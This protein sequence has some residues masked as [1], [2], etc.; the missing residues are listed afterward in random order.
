LRRKNACETLEPA[1]IKE[2][3][4]DSGFKVPKV[5]KNSRLR[6]LN[7]YIFNGNITE[8]FTSREYQDSRLLGPSLNRLGILREF[9]IPNI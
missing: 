8:P 2:K 5:T 9:P 4:L 3:D 1:K 6:N 7:R